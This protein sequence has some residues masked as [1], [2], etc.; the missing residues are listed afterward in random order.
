MMC[1]PLASSSSPRCWMPRW[2]RGCK[3]VHWILLGR[4]PLNGFSDLMWFMS[5]GVLL[6][7][8]IVSLTMVSSLSSIR[9]SC[10]ILRLCFACCQVAV[11]LLPKRVSCLSRMARVIAPIVLSLLRDFCRRAALMVV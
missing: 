10:L 1:V 7:C 2:K 9:D 8:G 5:S 11:S 6:N 4:T 3:N